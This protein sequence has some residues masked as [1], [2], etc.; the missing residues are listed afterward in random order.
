MFVHNIDP[1]LLHLG[2][3][4]I[5]YY[6][7]IYA[8]AFI[9]AL[10][11]LLRAVKKKD[12]AITKDDAYDLFFYLIIGVVAGA[13]LFEVLFYHPEL[14]FSSFMNLIAIWKGGLSFHGGLIGGFIA[15]WWFCRKKK[16]NFY[17]IADIIA[18][19][20]ALG[21]AFGRIA[22]FINAELI[23]TV[24]SL[25]WAVKFPGE[26]LYRH[27]VQLYES[28]KNFSIFF[29]LISLKKLK[30]KGR[31]DYQNGTIFWAFITL[32]A[33]IR[34]F[35]EFFKE[36]ETVYFGAPL[37]QILSMIMLIIGAYFLYK[38]NKAKPRAIQQHI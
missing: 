32:Y 20:A 16:I 17:E 1:V 22:N 11:Y 10:W 8:L 18:V 27:P 19:P 34:F 30:Y 28:L 4:G 35:I 26:E 14:Y 38:V 6:G 33:L 37:G 31:I 25:P 21:L 29:L 23:G 2:P 9:F 3:L 36:P 12:I 24:T 7:L 15:V 13:R 5:R